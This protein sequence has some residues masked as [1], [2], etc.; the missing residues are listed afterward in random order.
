M[1]QAKYVTLEKCHDLTGYSVKAL[2][3]KIESGVWAEGIHYRKAPDN[4]VL[5]DLDRFEKWVEKAA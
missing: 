3:R 1:K 2:R 4:R 5:V